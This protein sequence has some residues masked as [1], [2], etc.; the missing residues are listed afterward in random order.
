MVFDPQ[1]GWLP[2]ELHA[3]VP[4]NDRTGKNIT[5]T[6][7]TARSRRVGGVDAIDEAV[8]AMSN[9]VT[10]IW[11]IYHFVAKSM[12]RDDN[13]TKSALAIELPSHNVNL[14]DRTT[15]LVR[16]IDADGQ[17]VHERVKTSQE[18]VDDQLAMAAAFIAQ[19]ESHRELMRR[20]RIMTI[21]V[22]SGA[23]VTLG[24]AGI[25]LWRR[26]AVRIR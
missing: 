10:D 25:W 17:V 5:W 24:A 23:I 9:G 16:Y 3:Q 11:Q 8:F 20:Q 4:R 6:M 14:L 15:G 7:R 13:L 12:S 18:I 26:R 19:G 21:A 22:V 1:R 2:M